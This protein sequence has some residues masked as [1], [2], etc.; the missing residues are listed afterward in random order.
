[1]IQLSKKFGGRR[2]NDLAI[3][4]S[5]AASERM[6]QPP[7]KVRRKPIFVS[8][9]LQRPP[10]KRSS[11]Q[12]KFNGRRKKR[13]SYQQNFGGPEKTIQLSEKIRLQPKK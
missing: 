11:Y 1:M 6:I 2:E 10:R 8:A 13:P 5:S 12:Q 3:S 4:K 7:E 9:K